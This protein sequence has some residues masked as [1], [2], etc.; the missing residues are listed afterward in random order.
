MQ[1]TTAA[2]IELLSGNLRAGGER[3]Y[4]GVR[5]DEITPDGSE[6]DLTL[7]FKAGKRYCCPELGCHIGYSEVDWWRRL[8]EVMRGLG[9][10]RTPPMTIR[11]LRVVVESGARLECLTDFGRGKLRSDESEGFT[12]EA[13]PLAE[14]DAS[15]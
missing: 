12:Y 1:K 7:T 2:L 13:G 8:R 9:L 5:V 15:Y 10:A 6:F 4:Y 14:S 11:T 3:D